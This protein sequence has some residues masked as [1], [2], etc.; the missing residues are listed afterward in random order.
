MATITAWWLTDLPTNHF[1]VPLCQWFVSCIGG[2][3]WEKWHGACYRA[4]EWY[5]Y[6]FA[7][8][9]SLQAWS[10]GAKDLPRRHE[11][12]WCP[13]SHHLTNRKIYWR[14]GVFLWVLYYSGARETC[15]FQYNGPIYSVWKWGKTKRRAGSLLQIN[16]ICLTNVD[17][18]ACSL[19]MCATFDFDCQSVVAIIPVDL[20]LRAEFCK[21]WDEQ[22]RWSYSKNS[23]NSTSWD[24]RFAHNLVECVYCWNSCH[25]ISITPWR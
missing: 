14:H 10:T 15:S 23:Y 16:Q 9:W 21:P 20:S 12:F 1:L 7:S 24:L 19:G 6:V 5:A 17:K 25:H 4:T 8:A 11:W 13:C 3:A 22:Y 18:M 2:A